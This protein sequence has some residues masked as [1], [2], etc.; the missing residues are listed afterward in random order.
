VSAAS[1]RS[2]RLNAQAA[3]TKTDIVEAARRLFLERGYIATTLEMIAQTAEVAVQTIYNT[4]GSKR[5]VLNGVLDLSAAASAPRPVREFM[6]E[7][8]AATQTTG[9]MIG[10]L[11]DWFV[12]AGERTAPIQQIIRQAAAV[13]PEVAQLEKQRAR[14]RFE[15]YKLA[16]S[17]LAERGAMPREMTREEAAGLIWT[18][19]HPEVYRF[20]VLELE[21]PPARYRAWIESRLLAQFG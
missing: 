5:D 6:Q 14:Q 11:A 8:V 15:N 9:E 16:A 13:D 3:A 20:F 1:P 2:T 21:W 12:E 18:I 7:R 17:A 19:G 10:V 4:V